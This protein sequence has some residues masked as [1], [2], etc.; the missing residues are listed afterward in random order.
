[1]M[2]SSTLD[3]GANLLARKL[4]PRKDSV[5]ISSKSNWNLIH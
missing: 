4:Q 3:A 2:G 1:M 5:L